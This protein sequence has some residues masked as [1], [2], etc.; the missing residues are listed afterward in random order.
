M[1]KVRF[2][3]AAALKSYPWPATTTLAGVLSSASES[4]ARVAL[5]NGSV[6]RGEFQETLAANRT[7][8]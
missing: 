4:V 1:A 8:T 6:P 2:M 7:Q 3:N 5:D